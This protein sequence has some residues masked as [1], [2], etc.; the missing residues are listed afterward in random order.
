MIFFYKFIT[1]TVVAFSR[2]EFPSEYP[3]DPKEL[4][5]FAA[6]GLKRFVFLNNFVTN[7]CTEFSEF[8][9]VLEELCL[10]GFILNTFISLVKINIFSELLSESEN[11][12]NTSLLVVFI[13]K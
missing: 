4:F 6:I 2:T 1:D 8:C 12:M 3:F 11:I 13:K 5:V 10:S 7:Y 9:A